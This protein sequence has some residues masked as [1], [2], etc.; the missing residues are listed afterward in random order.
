MEIVRL[1]LPKLPKEILTKVRLISN[2][3]AHNDQSREWMNQFHNHNINAVNYQYDL[4]LELQ[5]EISVL[6]KEYFDDPLIVSIGVQRN[7]TSTLGTSPPHCDRGRHTVINYLIDCGG[8]DVQTHFY[9]HTRTGDLSSAENL[10]YSSIKITNRYRLAKDNWYCWN[11]QQCHSVEQ[12]E[13]IRIFIAL[14]LE[15]NPTYSNICENY[16]NLIAEAVACLN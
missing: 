7:I 5:D 13:T 10:N 12:L 8:E 16:S 2:L 9:N 14:I 4:L 1:N 15:T 11:A 3:M 6:Y